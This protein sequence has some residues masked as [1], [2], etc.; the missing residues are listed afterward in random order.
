MYLLPRYSTWLNFMFVRVH[1]Q[2]SVTGLVFSNSEKVNSYGSDC[3]CER[4]TFN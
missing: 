2:C 1:V 3:I 4:V